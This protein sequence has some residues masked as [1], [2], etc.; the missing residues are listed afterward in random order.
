[1]YRRVFP[2]QDPVCRPPQAPRYSKAS[3]PGPPLQAGIPPKCLNYEPDTHSGPHLW[4][5]HQAHS[6]PDA[7]TS[8]CAPQ[9]QRANKQMKWTPSR[10][11]WLSP[12]RLS[13]AK[14]EPSATV[15]AQPTNHPN[16]NSLIAPP[17]TNHHLRPSAP[18]P[19]PAP[20]STHAGMGRSPPTVKLLH[21]V[22]GSL[23][24]QTLFHAEPTPQG[25]GRWQGLGSRTLWRCEVGAASPL[26]QWEQNLGPQ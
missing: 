22:L 7:R 15:P 26:S 4:P 23:R 9:M 19:T 17:P 10:T 16:H 20:G 18:T 6:G 25:S 21:L 11:L 5:S 13:R 3:P 12:L 2:T 24:P 8:V 1:M 14:T